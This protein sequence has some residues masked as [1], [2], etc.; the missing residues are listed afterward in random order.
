MIFCSQLASQQVQNVLLAL[1]LGSQLFPVL[2]SWTAVPKKVKGR[3]HRQ[4]LARGKELPLA[5]IE[6]SH[7]HEDKQ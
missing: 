3:I 7:Q 4:L 2:N 1:N 6:S 5:E